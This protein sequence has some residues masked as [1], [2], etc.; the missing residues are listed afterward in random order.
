[1]KDE[2]KSI[3]PHPPLHSTDLPKACEMQGKSSHTPLPQT[4]NSWS[5]RYTRCLV[6]GKKHLPNLR[7]ASSGKHI[8]QQDQAKQEKL[9]QENMRRAETFSNSIL[10]GS[11]LKK[12][13]SGIFVN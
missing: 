11:L 13:P 10:H 3:S 8:P 5:G 2:P 9:Y 4:T 12:M 6:R 1:M 7:L